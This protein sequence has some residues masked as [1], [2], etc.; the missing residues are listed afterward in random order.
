MDGIAD[1]LTLYRPAGAGD[2]LEVNQLQWCPET[3]HRP[4][5][6]KVDEQLSGPQRFV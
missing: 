1:D 6:V 4:T 5:S 3:H 2:G